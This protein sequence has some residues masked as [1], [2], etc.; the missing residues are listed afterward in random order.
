LLSP[1][2]I[3]EKVQAAAR[4]TRP[5]VLNAAQTPSSRRW[6]AGRQEPVLGWARG[7]FPGWGLSSG[8]V[9]AVV[10]GRVQGLA[11]RRAGPVAGWGYPACA[12]RF[13]GRWDV[14]L[15]GFWP[16]PQKPPPGADH[17]HPTPPARD[18]ADPE[19]APA[20]PRLAAAQHPRE[21]AAAPAGSESL[22][23]RGAQGALQQR[24]RSATKL[25]TTG[26]GHASRPKPRTLACL[27]Q[28]LSLGRVGRRSRRL[29]LFGN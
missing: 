28:E 3:A 17:P 29:V 7:R 8:R 25:E 21:A 24:P 4:G 19:Q 23:G 11:D 1:R 9:R 6:D 15:A 12:A 5:L 18:A 2:G 26:P 10:S 16:C 14:A 22:E 20:Q 27:P 13:F